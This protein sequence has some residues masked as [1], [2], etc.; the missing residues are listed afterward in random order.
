M[1]KILIILILCFL[2][3]FL[4]ENKK[5]KTIE[6]NELIKKLLYDRAIDER[7]KELEIKY[8]FDFHYKKNSNHIVKKDNTIEHKIVKL[9]DN[10][11][12]LKILDPNMD[13]YNNYDRKYYLKNVEWE[14]IGFNLNIKLTHEDSFG[15]KVDNKKS[16]LI[17]NIPIIEDNVGEYLFNNFWKYQSNIPTQE[18]DENNIWMNNK[19]LSFDLN[20]LSK[21]LNIKF[22][23]N[24]NK[25]VKIDEGGISNTIITESI[26][27]NKLFFKKIY[28]ILNDQIE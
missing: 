8:I 11:V 15:R 13:V 16:K 3:Y 23:K 27:M 12:R 7:D 9:F 24:L 6:N 25:I 26:K 4:L 21:L 14:K 19:I 20:C 22:N 28:K 17:I 5:K 2:I 10:Y 1:V 18:Y